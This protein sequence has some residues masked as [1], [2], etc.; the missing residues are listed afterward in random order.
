MKALNIA[1]LCFWLL[2][3]S[4]SSANLTKCER[5]ALLDHTGKFHQLSYY[6][7]QRG[8]VLYKARGRIL[9]REF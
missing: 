3:S 6:G 5:F 4:A 2:L 8:V 7:D 9:W 1:V